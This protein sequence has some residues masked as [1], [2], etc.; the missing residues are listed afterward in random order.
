MTHRIM[1]ITGIKKR[2]G[3]RHC[4]LKVDAI[5]TGKLLMDFLEKKHE[6]CSL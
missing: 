4:F 1:Q 5:M 3:N 6:F 2:L